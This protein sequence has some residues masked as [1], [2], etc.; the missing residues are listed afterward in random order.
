VARKVDTEDYDKPFWIEIDRQIVTPKVRRRVDWLYLEDIIMA[1]MYHYSNKARHFPQCQS[2]CE[3]HNVFLRLQDFYYG[4]CREFGVRPP[5]PEYGNAYGAREPDNIF[6][7][8]RHISQR[9]LCPGDDGYEVHSYMA[10]MCRVLGR[11]VKKASQ[12]EK[13]MILVGRVPDDVKPDDLEELNAHWNNN[14]TVIIVDTDP[15]VSEE[16]ERMMRWTKLELDDLDRRDF[17]WC[18]DF[19]NEGEGELW[20][21]LKGQAIT[22]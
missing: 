21:A 6:A 7:I 19:M 4:P 14:K 10:G 9:H 18:V 8:N 20:K 2:I 11:I 12:A 1:K 22:R 17:D 16:E 5:A 15:P 13:L 3:V